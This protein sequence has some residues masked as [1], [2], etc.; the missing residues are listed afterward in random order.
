MDNCNKCA[1][2]L[3]C[4][5][6]FN[7]SSCLKDKKSE[8][9]YWKEI[10]EA[11]VAVGKLERIRHYLSKNPKIIRTDIIQKWAELNNIHYTT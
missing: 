7:S 5:G 4:K 6:I 9:E 8:E 2:K 3:V 1:Y 10:Q 11:M